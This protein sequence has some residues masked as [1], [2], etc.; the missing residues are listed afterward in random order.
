MPMETRVFRNQRGQ[1]VRLPEAEQ[2][3]ESVKRVVITRVGSSR[4][5]SPAG[6]EWDE[7][8]AGEKVSEDFMSDRDQPSQSPQSSE[9]TR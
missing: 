7:F 3:P 2:F 9:P 6:R 8:F 1:T 4:L 5:I